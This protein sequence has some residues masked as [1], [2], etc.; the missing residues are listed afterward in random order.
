M[1]RNVHG[2]SPCQACGKPAW[3]L[4]LGC[5]HEGTD[6]LAGYV[7]ED[8]A[9]A[10]SDHEDYGSLPLVNSPRSGVCAYDGPAE[11]PW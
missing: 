10:H 2:P 7:C 9:G 8:D 6:D 1:A 11:P 3:F 4:C 5:H